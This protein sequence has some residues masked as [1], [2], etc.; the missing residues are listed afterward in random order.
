MF[1]NEGQRW[2]KD[3]IC[4][5]RRG[6]PLKRPNALVVAVQKCTA[7]VS[8]TSSLRQAEGMTPIVPISFL[9]PTINVTPIAHTYNENA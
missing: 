4:K 6:T 1:S 9:L 7:S 3:S 8:P 2:L 5:R